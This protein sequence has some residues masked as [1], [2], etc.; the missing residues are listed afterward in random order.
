[1]LDAIS[2]GAVT[3][4]EM[5]RAE[6]INPTANHFAEPGQAPIL[7]PDSPLYTI[8]Q[9]SGDFYDGF[10]MALGGYYAL[11]IVDFFQSRISRRHI[12]R[13]LQLA[14]GMLFSIG[15][16]GILE[17]GIWHGTSTAD[18]KDI[19]AGV[20]GALTHGAFNVL[21]RKLVESRAKRNKTILAE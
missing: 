15:I 17:S 8:L 13:R 14:I 16:V 9:C 7:S 19:P 18:I 10:L 21:S 6:L 4:A 12:P 1:M 11:K 3:G 20:T 2:I 5:V